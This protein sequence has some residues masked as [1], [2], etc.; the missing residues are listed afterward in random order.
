VG[1]L[2]LEP[3]LLVSVARCSL[4]GAR[5]DAGIVLSIYRRSGG[6]PPVFPIVLVF[7][8][9]QNFAHFRVERPGCFLPVPKT[10]ALPVGHIGFP[11]RMDS[12]HHDACKDSRVKASSGLQG[13][14]P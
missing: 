5:Y 9:R 12:N 7:P 10:G 8:S 6:Q 4:A 11:Q 13:V 2:G 3:S 1:N 14:E